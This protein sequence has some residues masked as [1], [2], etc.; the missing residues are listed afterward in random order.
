MVCPLVVGPWWASELGKGGFATL[1][2]FDKPLKACKGLLRGFQG[3][4][5]VNFDRL[6][7]LYDELEAWKASAMVGDESH[8]IKSPSAQRA[9]A[10]RRLAWRCPWVRLLTGTAAPNHYGDLWGQLSALDAKEWG[11]TFGKFAGQYLIRHPMFPSQVVGYRNLKELRERM[12]PYVSTVRR[13]DVFGPDT[14]QVVAR[15]VD[16]PP[17]ARELYNNLAT[18]WMAEYEGGQVSADHVLK[19]LT[20]LQQVAAGYV[21]ND[22]GVIMDVHTAKIDAVVG[23]LEEIFESG[24]KAVLFHRFRWEGEHYERAIKHL[25]TVYRISGDTPVRDRDTI[26]SCMR[27]VAGGAVAVVQVQSGGVGISFAEATH[28]LFV[29]RG[30]SYSDDQQARDRIYKPGARRVVSYYTCKRT[31]DEYIA[32]VLNSKQNVH[33]AVA[34]MDIRAMA[35]GG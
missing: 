1:N 17:K 19:R 15:S 32:T 13:E 12:L 9:R 20:R 28:A 8:L 29:S 27:D 7:D 5:I 23:D 11:K 35:Y 6:A 22:D 16:L 4:V 26:V 2:L 3:A 10:F 21:P 18:D 34:H 14:W 25:G 31:V 24:E 30:F 33:E